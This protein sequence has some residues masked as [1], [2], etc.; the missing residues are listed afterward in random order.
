[1]AKFAQYDSTISGPSPVIGWYDLDT[2]S[3]PNMP[4]DSAL[5]ELTTDEWLAHFKNASNWAVHDGELVPYVRPPPPLTPQRQMAAAFSHGCD[6]TS[7]SHPELN[8]TY[9]VVG[10]VWQ[11]MRDEA[12]HISTFGD[13]SADLVTLTWPVAGG[14]TTVFNTTADFLVVVKG[15]AKW[16]TLW[17]Q[18]AAE[19]V[20]ESPSAGV[21]VP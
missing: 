19:Q 3:Y 4:P 17:K 9:A 21:Q 14:G 6:V 10:Q 8:A 20:S 1:M 2:L 11:D 12:Q 13:F 7:A 16:I 15:I 18:F 5:L